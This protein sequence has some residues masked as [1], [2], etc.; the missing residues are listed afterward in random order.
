MFYP[1]IRS[2]LEK[3]V[4]ISQF[5]Q[6]LKSQVQGWQFYS[7]NSSAKALLAA[8]AFHDYKRP[9]LLIA[10]DDKAAEDYA[11]DLEILVGQERAFFLPDYEVLPYEERSPHRT[12]RGQ[13]IEALARMLSGKPAIYTMS[14]RTLIRKI[15]PASY[16]SKHIITLRPGQQYPPEQLVSTLSGNGYDVEYQVSTVGQVAK[17]GGIVDVFSPHAIHPVRIEFFGDEVESIRSF[18]VESQRSERKMLPEVTLLPSREISYHDIQASGPLLDLV[19][20]KGFYE[21]IELDVSLLLPSTDCIFDYLADKNPIL[22]WD[23]VEYLK[24]MQL[25]IWE[26][27]TALYQKALKNNP[28]RPVPTPE[29]LYIHDE[30]LTKGL[31]QTQCY[32]LS[33]SEQQHVLI[34]QSLGAPCYSQPHLG[35]DIPM[36]MN[37]VREHLQQ[38]YRIFIQ[39]DNQSQ[40]NRMQEIMAEFEDD[41]HFCIGVLHKGFI[42]NDIRLAVYTDHEIFSRYKRR[43]TQARFSRSQ[44]L[45]DYESLKPGDYIVHID[46]GIGIYEGLKKVELDG[47]QIECL[48][49]RY[50]SN[51]RIYV[52]TFQ[53]QLVS[54]FVSD[55]GAEPVIHKLGSHRW[56]NAKEK[57]KKQIE[58]VAEDILKLYAE[59]SLRQGILFDKDSAW[60]KE[61]EDSFIYEDTVDQKR[62][63][64]EIKSD[65]EAP[66]PMERLLCGDVGFGKTEVAIRAAFKAVMSGYQV[67]VLVPTTLLAEQHYRVFRERLAEY[68]VRIA[69]FSRFRTTAQMQKDIA[70][71]EN[72]E[73]DI[74]IGTHRLISKDVKFHR[75][76]L[77]I[78][79][80]EHRFGVRHKE[81]IRKFKSQID[82]LYM[83]ATPIPRTMS[84]ALSKLKEISLIQTSPKE[85]L[86]IRTLVTPYDEDVIK[87]AIM[88]EVDRGGQ[89][90]YLHNRVQSIE[91]LAD[92]LRESLPNVRF[93]VGHAQ[94][95]ERQLERVMEAFVEHEFDVLV[96]T[97]IIENGID[98]PNAN[99]IIIDRADTFG[100]AQLYQMRGR[101]GRSNRRAYA[102][103]LIPK[104]ITEDA[105][106]RLDALTEYD[107]LGAGFQV[108]MRDLEIRGAGTLLGIKQSG[109]INSVG[110]NYYNRLLEQAV[111]NLLKS[112]PN[113]LWDEEET[114]SLQSLRF[115]SD[116]YLPEDYIVDE[117]VRLEIYKRMLQLEDIDS[118]SAL[119]QELEDRFGK[120]PEQAVSSMEYF[121]LRLLAGK[122]GMVSCLLK[123]GQLVMEFSASRMPSREHILQLLQKVSY[124][125]SF[126]STNGFRIILQLQTGKDKKRGDV[127]KAIEVLQVYLSI[128]SQKK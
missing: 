97:T 106:K 125:V 68:P 1:E 3:S 46:H 15:V 115:D 113:G 52:P 69:M 73:I 74:A 51:D 57:A 9:V 35:G 99:T 93:E 92:R 66:H 84:M 47:N 95:A 49:L 60:Q 122:A 7:L 45:N 104:G 27:T 90:F 59:R 127:F 102:Y 86:P 105:R 117:K 126:D 119:Q 98:I 12:I 108:A 110:F 42:F 4:F 83:S 124:Q 34:K 123:G 58:L 44:A 109:V 94:M 11:E 91:A 64:N 103:L 17:R 21:G 28:R 37:Q 41:L 8:R 33:H 6:I 79:D 16:L 112:N 38:G 24:S 22:F 107:Y 40:S 2:Y 118:F 62:A 88:R 75:I 32:Y 120:L 14:L 13:R 39:S 96:S 18:S 78:V 29:Q 63:V 54:R 26:E 71:L 128:L 111:E 23:E 76:G 81:A 56:E 100:L 48:C 85:R 80:E 5:D 70:K 19:R 20:D 53:L 101:V 55:E 87:D 121:K 116:V 82:T 36:F 50:A 89:V 31:L 72:G 30:V 10:L 77:L 61:M 114:Q 25:E 43:K 65:M 67:A